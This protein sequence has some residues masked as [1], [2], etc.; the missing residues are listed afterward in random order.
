MLLF[1]FQSVGLGAVEEVNETLVA[2]ASHAFKLYAIL[3][4]LES[5]H[6]LDAS[7]LSGLTVDVHVDLLEDE[8]RVVRDVTLVDW[9]NAL[10]RWAPRGCEVDN[11]GLASSSCG[12]RGVERSL[13]G[14]VQVCHLRVVYFKSWLLCKKL[15][16]NFPKLIAYIRLDERQ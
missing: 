10:A 16:I 3:V 9:A 8:L 5:G 12:D 11:K 14:Q 1:R 7:C 13:I 15:I 4:D 2:G 6:R